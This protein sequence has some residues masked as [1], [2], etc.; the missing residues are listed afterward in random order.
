MAGGAALGQLSAAF[1][2]SNHRFD[3]GGAQADAF[4]RANAGDGGAPPGR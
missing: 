3:Q 2:S 1:R 4:E